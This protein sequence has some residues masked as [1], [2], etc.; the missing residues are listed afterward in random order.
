MI[1]KERIINQAM[2]MF[3]EQGIK[4]VRMDDIAHQL[5]VSKRTLYEMFG[6]KEELLHLAMD[7]YFE[8][9]EIQQAT[10]IKGA[11]NII[12]AMFI[13]LRDV[14]NNSEKMN[15]T[16]NTLLKFYPTVY[17]KLMAA[18][19]EKRRR[20]LKEGIE[21]GMKEGLFIQNINLDLAIVS[22]YFTVSAIIVRKEL[23]LPTKLSEREAF[24]QIVSTF[25]RGIATTKGLEMIDQYM[26]EKE[27]EKENNNSR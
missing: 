9:Y 15:R 3:V 10:L 25:F 6:D 12:E 8:A 11:N 1:Q 21:Q 27:L 4:T 13:V 24:M 26:A 19:D 23:I 20:N 5:C 18:G 7:R 14:L 17:N 16:V 22:L 2:Q